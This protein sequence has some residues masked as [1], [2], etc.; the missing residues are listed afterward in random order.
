[1]L[2]GTEHLSNRHDDLRRAIHFLA[3]GC[4]F[5]LRPLGPFWG[6]ML[7]AAA[8]AYNAFVAPAFRLDRAYRR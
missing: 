7:A 5:L 6:A 8:L 2:S 3:G 1:L 4:A